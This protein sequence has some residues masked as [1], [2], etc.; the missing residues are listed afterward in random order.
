MGDYPMPPGEITSA[1]KRGLVIPAHPLALTRERKLDEKRQRALTR[2]Y[3]AAGAGGLAVGV[4]T[5]QFEIHRPEVGLYRSVLKLAAETTEE[6]ERREKRPV[7]KVAGICGSTRQ[8]VSEARFAADLGYHAGLL[9]LSEFR[10]AP[11]EK[12]LSH[13]RAV[14]EEIPLFGFYLQPAVGGRILSYEFWR[15]FVEIENV[16]AIKIA[17]FNRY[18]TIDVVRAVAEA[19]RADEIALYTG[20]DDNIVNDLLTVFSFTVNREPVNVRIVGGLLGQ[21]AV[22]TRRAVEL[23]EEIHRVTASGGPIPAGLLTLGAQITDANSAIFDV[24]HSF[25]GCIPGIHE[26]LRRQGLLEGRWCL[27]PGLDLSEGQMEEIDR[28]YAAYPHLNDDSF[29][30]D[31]LDEWI[32]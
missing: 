10:G 12:I 16:V 19:G 6:Y 25:A 3:L 2:C 28:V 1:L 20:N 23:L 17:P 15:R 30:A 5:T 22:W 29:V 18:F 31:H 8:A 9:S 7:V 4:H 13:C 26:V 27:D 24:A 21:W 11:V 14:A 32:E